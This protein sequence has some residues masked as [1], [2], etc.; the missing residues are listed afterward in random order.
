MKLSALSAFVLLVLLGHAA[1]AEDAISGSYSYQSMILTLEKG[2]GDSVAGELAGGGNRYALRGVM[3][4]GS[5]I[6][7][8]SGAETRLGF[9]AI[10]EGDGLL[11][12]LYGLDAAGM[13]QRDRAERYRFVRSQTDRA[14]GG[15]YV[16]GAALD[17]KTRQALQELYRVRVMDGHYWYDALSG[18][19]GVEGGPTA[20]FLVSGLNL[21]GT[22]SADASGGSTG[23]FFNGR[24]LHVQDA[25][26]LRQLLGTVIPGRYS[27]DGNGNLYVENGR[28]LLNL[29]QLARQAQGSTSYR[30]NIT[31][32]G[33]GSSGGTSYVM[34]SDWS[35][36]V[37]D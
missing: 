5:A 32:I 9:E 23:V 21:G 6:G 35:V 1:V 10:P 29:V 36:I 34:G 20:G 19:W 26:A 7:S 11:L 3:Q 16:N 31:G 22:L 33:A 37:G 30:S 18:A 24:E 8:V 28:W 12:V 2:A 14:T 27:L 13:P 17:D 4:S 15:V 25:L